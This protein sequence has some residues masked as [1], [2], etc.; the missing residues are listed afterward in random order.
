MQIWA[1]CL[2]R[3]EL[4]RVLWLRVERPIM[5]ALIASR[6]LMTLSK[7]EA[8]SGPLL[9]EERT[10]MIADAKCEEANVERT[11]RA[12]WRDKKKRREAGRT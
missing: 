9:A 4:A 1:V 7:H 2:D 10:K 12:P 11:E 8:L 5:N 6:L 3:F